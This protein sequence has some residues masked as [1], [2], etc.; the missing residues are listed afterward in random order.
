MT[1]LLFALAL[2]DAAAWIERLADSDPGR[3]DE[4]EQKLKALGDDVVPLLRTAAEGSDPEVSARAKGILGYLDRTRRARKILAVKPP[5]SIDVPTDTPLPDVTKRIGDH[6][7]VVFDLDEVARARTWGGKI[8][9]ATLL[10]TLDRVAVESKTAYSVAPGRVRMTE[11][12]PTAVPSFYSGPFRV[13]APECGLSSIVRYGSKQRWA[14]VAIDVVHESDLVTVD[15]RSIV[16]REVEF[17]TGDVV[18]ID[19]TKDSDRM[20]YDPDRRGALGLRLQNPPEGVAAIR[21]I[22]GV[23]SVEVPADYET[24]TFDALTVGAKVEGALGTAEIVSV[25]RGTYGEVDLW[26]AFVSI[27]GAKLG[28]G[29]PE[30]IMGAGEVVLFSKSGDEAPLPDDWP[31]RH[32]WGGHWQTLEVESRFRIPVDKKFEPARLAVKLVREYETVEVP[33]EIRDVPLR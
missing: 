25:D 14:T 23:V 6:F 11:G 21:S 22:R 2:Q 13:S 30:K 12:E 8:E 19:L 29:G 3:R 10:Q 33:F 17:D 15:R 4:A 7:G 18:K 28:T 32:A 27:K 9:G 20:V 16:V 1:S 24:W 31:A 5:L 26:T